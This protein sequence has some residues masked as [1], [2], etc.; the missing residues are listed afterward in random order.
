M[1]SIKHNIYLKVQYQMYIEVRVQWTKYQNTF[2]IINIDH[3][4]NNNNI[5]MVVQTNVKNGE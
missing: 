4:I 2:T 1:Y 5:Y 3:N